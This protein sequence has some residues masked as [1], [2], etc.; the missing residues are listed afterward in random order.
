MATKAEL[1]LKLLTIS[2]LV[3]QV[4]SCN[5]TELCHRCKVIVSEVRDLCSTKKGETHGSK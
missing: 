1:K 5:R 3:E 2:A 4:D